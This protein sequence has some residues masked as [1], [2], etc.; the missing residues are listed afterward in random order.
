MKANNVLET[1]G[2]TP[3][4]RMSPP[5]PRRRGLDQVRA[6]Q[7][8]R[9]DQ[10]PHRARHDRGRRGR[11][12]AQARRH[13]HRADLGQHRHRPRHGRRR[14]GLQAHPGHAREHVRRAPPADAGLWRHLRPD[15]PGGRHEGRH[16]P[17]E[18]LAAHSPGAWIPQQFENPA[19]IDDPRPHHGA[20]R[21]W[22]TSPTASTRII[23]GVGTGGH[24]TGCAEVLKP[25]WPDLQVF[26][27]EPA[28]SP[29]ISGGAPGA[30]PDP[31]HRRRL[32][33][34]EP[35]HATC[36]TA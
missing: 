24:I 31:G 23:T 11:A 18:E 25:R 15:A 36:W 3:H 1:I 26:A 7:P 19:N 20:R 21:S 34:G 28:L 4:I 17:R 29:V 10:G 5:V 33:P 30:A 16:R 6:R 13:H 32:R 8:R 14:Q 27:V 9:L 35:A 2:R 12:A 22:P